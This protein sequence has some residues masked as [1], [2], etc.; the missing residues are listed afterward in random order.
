DLVER[1]DV[2]EAAVP[3]LERIWTVG[4]DAGRETWRGAAVERQPE[5]ADPLPAH[6]VDPATL[7]AILYT[8]GT[9]G[10]PKGVCCPHGQFYWWGVLMGE[11]LGMTEADVAYTVLP[12][13]HTNAL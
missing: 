7:G 3:M 6:P 8:S 13:F 10:P 1:L 12:L 11:M 9:T 2:L 4:A 5:L